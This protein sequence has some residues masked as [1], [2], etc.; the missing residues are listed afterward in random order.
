MRLTKRKVKMV[1]WLVCLL[2]LAAVFKTC[3]IDALVTKGGQ[4]LDNLNSLN[5]G[6]AS[7]KETATYPGIQAEAAI[8]IDTATGKILY[9]KNKDKR[10]YPA[11]TTK[12]MTALLL[13]EKK[14]QKDVLIYSS[15]AKQQ[16]ANK[17]DFAQ[18]SKMTADNAMQAMLIF[19]ANDIAY[20]IGENISGGMP[21]FVEL[22]NK[23]AASLG[24]SGTHLTNPCG[25]HNANHYTTASDLSVMARE[26][27][28]NNWIMTTMSLE[29]AH[30]K[31]TDG[32]GIIVYNTNPLL[33]KYGC[34]GGKTGYTSQ[35]GKCLAAYFKKENQVVISIVLNSPDEETLSEDMKTIVDWSFKSLN[36]Q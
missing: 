10:M 4:A 33:K 36:N 30:I 8:A 3:S 23:K 29:S 21:Q 16:E 19:S 2:M 15:K 26:A 5:D 18:G 11:S 31:K 34:I 28:R 35:A 6:K 14:T 22:M 25:L 17:L 27:Y 24:L 20:M 13:A 32:Q 1:F 9:A 7:E 12:L